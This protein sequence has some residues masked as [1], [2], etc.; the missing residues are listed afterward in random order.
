M[1]THKVNNIITPKQEWS[2]LT[3]TR[4]HA[5][6]GGT[7]Q[8]ERK[9]QTMRMHAS[10]PTAHALATSQHATGTTL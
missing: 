2:P 7:G 3:E 10:P 9:V 6:L 5:H 8:Q 1:T 4:D